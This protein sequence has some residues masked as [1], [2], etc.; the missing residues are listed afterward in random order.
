[1]GGNR[2]SFRGGRGRGRG[3]G[4]GRGRGFSFGGRETAEQNKGQWQTNERI[5][6]PEAGITQYISEAPGFQGVIKSR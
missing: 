4:R 1:M 2:D 5:S 3:G 6:E